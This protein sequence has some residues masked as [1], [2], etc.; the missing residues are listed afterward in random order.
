MKIF[1]SHSS[2]DKDIVEKV[3]KELGAG[4]CHYD[5]ATFD[6]TGFLPDQ[7]YSALA[8]STHFVLF[9]SEKALHSDWVKGELK[10]QFINWMRSKTASAMVF[11][12]RGGDRSLIPDWLQNYV[13]TEHP[14]PTH[15]ACRI[16]SEYDR[17]QN[18]ESNIPP[19]YRSGELKNLEMR[20][21]VEAAK[22]PACLL[23]C[24][25]DG[26]GR[27]ELINQV[28]S[29]NFRNVSLRKIH[30]YTENFDSDVDFYKSLKG[31]FSLTT[32]RDLVNAVDSYQKLPL[33]Q[34]LDQLVELIQ[35]LCGGS[36]TIILDAADS[37]FDDSGEINDW[38]EQ[39]IK[40]LP[41]MSYPCLNITTNRKPYF[42]KSSITE[43]TVIC[44]LDP[45]STQDSSLLFHWWLNKLEVSLPSPVLELI[46]EQIIGNPKQIESAVRLLKNIPDISDIRSIKKNVFA[47]LDRNVSKLLTKVASDDC[48]KL[49]MSLIADCGNIAVSD[50]VTIVAQITNQDNGT[51]IDCYKK[52]NSYGFIQSD[53]ICIKIPNF[54]IRTAK[55]LGK[56]EPITTQLKLCWCALAKSM[57]NISYDDETS[58]TIL[59]EACILKLKSGVNSIIGI[60]SL[61]L[62]SQCLRTARQ[63][64]DSNQY[65]P[66]YELSH[67]AFIARLALTDDGAIEALRYCGMSAARLNRSDLLKETLDNFKEYI[68]HIRAQRISEFIQ[69]FDFRL[70]GKF[71][72]ALIHMQK[73]LKFKGEKD[74]HVLRELASLC[75]STNDLQKAKTYINKIAKQRNNSF[76]LELQILIELAFGKGYVIHNEKFILELLDDLE[77]VDTFNNKNH[78]F[79]VKIEYL[80][81]RGDF[82]QAREL[83]ER[84]YKEGGNSVPK[85]LLE[86]KLLVAEKN[87]YDA[88]KLLNKTKET[89]FATKDP[90]RRSTL[91]MIADL[92]IQAASGVSISNGIEEFEQNKKY[93]PSAIREKTKSELSSQ[94]AYS[95]YKLSVKE[96]N[97]LGL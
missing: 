36:Q 70:A 65:M 50:L 21:L 56:S 63:L 2:S 34:R 87:F 12:L 72:D 77:S 73:A 47:D 38:M 8:E 27:K 96:K 13:I 53:A 88:V 81:T 95:K 71:D 44:Y 4:I 74:V 60:E 66:A 39:L 18:N 59:N 43:R 84:Y 11:L 83:F 93:L 20:L 62:P 24:G 67:R 32:A 31:V 25:T 57:G 78:A 97:T 82:Q 29:R 55:S 6:P 7:I 28:F 16:L 9:A 3:Y 80:L 54:L 92:L 19:F 64:Y 75:L 10:N 42:I 41:S 69:G 37:I 5:V 91:P 49:L 40:K 79:R 14:T 22:M 1:L 86:A 46:L 30:I 15:I 26:F 85:N 68:N 23:V 94:V 89:V 61:I 51:I 48:S 76:I 33:D 17:W 35:Q 52:L 90:Q 58:Y 45:L